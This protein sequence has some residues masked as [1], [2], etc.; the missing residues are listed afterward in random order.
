MALVSLVIVEMSCSKSRLLVM[1]HKI[2]IELMSGE[3]LANL[4]LRCYSL[5][6]ISLFLSNGRVPS[7]VEKCSYHWKWF[8][9]IG[10]H[11]SSDNFSGCSGQEKVIRLL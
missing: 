6:N 11:F 5:E 9:H 3:L 8:W 7:S 2:L 1:A 10:N 4:K